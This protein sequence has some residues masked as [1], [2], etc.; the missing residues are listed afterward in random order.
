[1]VRLLILL[2][3]AAILLAL[4]Y[5]LFKSISFVKKMLFVGG[6]LA[7]AA[8]GLFMQMSFPWHMVLLGIVAVALLVSLV[9]MKL[10]E[11]EQAEKQRLHE[12]R[13]S[14]RS[15]PEPERATAIELQKDETIENNT[16]ED[17]IIPDNTIQDSTIQDKPASQQPVE[18][19]TIKPS[20]GMESIDPDREER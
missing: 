11:K 7:A 10:L 16:M 19:T 15:V 17:T 5:F 20:F 12:E 3:F 18:D 1:M 2:I 6:S 14:R 8:V 13:K 9:F 4:P